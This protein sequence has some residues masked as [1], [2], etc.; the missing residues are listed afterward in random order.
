MYIFSQHFY[1]VFGGT[2]EVA[3]VLRSGK[4]GRGVLGF[5]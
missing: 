3:R 5:S 2:A 1:S 4:A